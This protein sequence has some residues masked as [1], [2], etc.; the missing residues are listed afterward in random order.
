MSENRVY[1]FSAGP[2]MLPLPVLE[3]AASELVSYGDCGMSVMEMSHRSRAYQD[4]FDAAKQGL[5]DV[6]SVPDSYDI[7]F[8][9]GGAT[10]QFAALPMNLIGRTGKADYVVTGHFSRLAAKE[11]RKYGAVH[12]SASTEDSGHNRIPQQ[13]ELRLA[14]DASYLH[15]C[16]NNTIYGTEWH[17]VPETGLVP[18]AADCSSELLSKPID[19]TKYGVIYAG[20]QKNMAPAG[21]AVVIIR[22]DLLG[23]EMPYTPTIM[24]YAV[25]SG[26]NSMYNT[27]P[28]YNIYILGLVLRWIREQGG[29]RA[30]EELR[31]RRS[32]LVYDFLD[33][34]R[35]FV[36]SV[37][38]DSRSKMNVTF[39]TGDEAL[40][41]SF[42]KEASSRGLVNLKGHRLTGGMRASMYNAMPVEGA[43]KLVSFMKEFELRHK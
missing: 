24:S 23:G 36:S 41:A 15:L 34:S 25:M 5:R 19:V 26:K 6:L 21:M 9:Q 16:A 4:I 42:V 35:L 40:D 43:E 27:P 20:V 37:E 31:E 2:S 29:L 39:R 22:R 33:E 3:R 11:A 10:L 7:L 18:V 28:T 32:G 14:I 1:N 38:R 17:Y 30:M 12:I 8:M 13:E